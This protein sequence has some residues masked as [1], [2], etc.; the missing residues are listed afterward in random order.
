MNKQGKESAIVAAISTVFAI[1]IGFV[2][3]MSY[4]PTAEIIKQ[5]VGGIL[6]ILFV[7][8]VVGIIVG[9]I[10]LIYYFSDNGR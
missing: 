6:T 3:F 1:F 4:P 7:V 5:I 10:F 9:I 2:L 8:A